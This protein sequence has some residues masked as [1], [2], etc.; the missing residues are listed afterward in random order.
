MQIKRFV[1]L[2]LCISFGFLSLIAIDSNRCLSLGFNTESLVCQ[3]CD[4]LQRV[5][6][7]D[8]LF[9]DCLSCCTKITEENLFSR[10]VLEVD[11]RFVPSFPNL[12]SIIK[13]IKDFRR[14][15]EN[16]KI[17]KIRY[18]FGSPPL[19]KLFKGEEETS[20]EVV[21]LHSWSLDDFTDY[22]KEHLKHLVR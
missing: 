16:T 21:P 4:H 14:K 7:D 9:N 12:P 15:E 3:T 6:G 18:R 17:L 2:L 5:L 20:S 10:V 22:I 8:E 1:F 13:T 19:L 11:D